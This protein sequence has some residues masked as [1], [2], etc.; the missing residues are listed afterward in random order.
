MYA[1]HLA[2]SAI[3]SGDCDGAIVA[4]ANWINDPSM[5][6]VLDKLGALSPTSRCHTFDAAADGYARGEGFAA[7]YLKKSTVALLDGL[8]IRAMIRGTAVNANG[9]T[10]GITR[11]SARGQEDAIRKAYE[12]AGNLPFEDTA[13]FECHG[14]GTPA[15][16]PLEVAAVGNVFASSRRSGTPEDRLLIGSIKPNLGHTEGASAIASI[17]KVVLSLEAGEIAPTYGVESLN[18]NIDFDGAKVLVVKDGAVP[19]PEGKVRRAS[20]NS[21]GFGGANGHCIIDHVNEVLPGY[22]K[23]G[24]VTSTSPRSNGHGTNGYLNGSLPTNGHVNGNAATHV[25]KHSPFTSG[26]VKKTA[27]ATASTR[28]IVLLPFSAHNT[29]SLQLNIE[30]ISQAVMGSNRY[31]LADVAYTL[32]SKRSR[33]QQRTFRIVDTKQDDIAAGIATEKRVF[34]SPIQTSNVAFIFTGQGAQWH[35]MGAQ[36]FEYGVFRSTISYLDYVL[37]EIRQDSEAPDTDP[38]SGPSA[39]WTIASTLSGDCER[40]HIQ[41]PYVSQVACTAIQLALVDLLASWS[42]RPCAVV[43]HSSGEMAAAYAAG[44]LTAAE[45]IAAAYFRGRAVALNKQKGAMLAVGVGADLVAPYLQGKEEQIRIAAMNSPGSITLSGDIDA[46]DEVAAALSKDGIFHRVLRTSGSAYHSHHMLAVGSEYV[47]MLSRGV[48]CLKKLGLADDS[49]RYPGIPWVS[50]VRPD[51]TM[52]P[53]QELAGPQYWRENL[54]SPVRFTQA[55][56]RLMHLESKSIDILVEIGPHAA[57]KGP[58]EQILKGIG[59]PAQ[60]ISGL[61]R[62]EDGRSSLMQLAGTLFATNAEIDLAAVNSVDAEDDGALNSGPW[63]PNFI[64]GCVAVDLPTYQYTYGP[65]SYY[66]SRMSKEFRLREYL[67]HD[68]LGSD[69][70]AASK[71]HPQWR[72]VLRTKDI[73]W[74]SDHRLLP[75]AVFPAA[76]YIALGVE[77]ASRVYHALPDALGV[78]GYSFREVSIDAALII[79]EDDYGIEIIVSMELVDK[80]TAKAPAWVKFAVT[81]VARDSNDWTQHCTGLVKVEVS[82]P[83]TKVQMST[84]MDPRLPS[85]RAWYDK[86]NDI[87]LGYGKTFQ[88]LSDLQVDPHRKLARA[89]VSLSSTADSMTGGES[90]YPLHPAALDAAFQ[91]AIIAFHG[92][93]LENATAAFVPVR[94][95]QLYL[96]TGVRQDLPATALAHGS[97]SGLR[98]AYA[99]LQ[100]VD[101]SGH[102]FLEVDSMRFAEFRETKTHGMLSEQP[103]SSPFTR[104]VWQPDIRSLSDSQIR[105]I[106]PPPAE[107]TEA[108]AALEVIEMICCLVAFEIYES[109]VLGSE[110]VSPKGDIRHWLA[111]IKRIVEEDY[112]RTQMVEARKLSPTQRRELLGQLYSEAGDRPEAQAAKLLHTNA[113]D[114][115]HERRTGIDILISHK[116]LTPLYEVGTAIAGSHPQVF[117]I[118]GTL[119]HANPN[120]RILEIGAGTGAATRA[121][122][123]ALVGANGIK[124]Y[125]DYTFTDISA[126]FLTSA[127]EMLSDHRDITYSVLDIEQD[128]ISHGYEAVYDIVLACEAIHATESMDRTLAH[129]RSLLKPGGKLVLVETTRMRVLLGLLYG[130]LTGYWQSDDRTEGPFMSLETWQRRLTATG[131]SGVDLHVDDYEAPHN[132]TSVLVTTRVDEQQDAAEGG[133]VTKLPGKGV[134]L[135]HLLDSNDTAPALSIQLATEL[136]RRGVTCKSFRLPRDGSEELCLPTNARVI[137]LLSDQNDLFD[138][139]THRLQAFQY[140]ARSVKSMVW[141]TV[142]SIVKGQDPRGAFMTGLLRVVATENPAGRFLSINI[143]GCI[144]FANGDDNLVRSIVDKEFA[145]QHGAEEDFGEDEQIIDSEFVWQAGCMWVSR[146]VPDTGLGKYAEPIKTPSRQGLDVL[147]IAGHGPVRAAFETA[148][149]FTSVYFR[150]YTEL[151]QPLPVDHIEVKVAAAGLNWRDVTVAMGR[152]NAAGCNLSSEYAGVVTKIGADVTGLSVGD[153]VYGL[154]KGHFGNYE[155]VPAAF[156]QRLQSTDSLVEAAAVPLDFL[157]AVYAFEY[158]TRLRKGCKVLIESTADSLGLAA[159]QVAQAKGA[160]VFAVADTTEKVSTLADIGGIPRDHV[161]LLS[162]Q[163]LLVRATN[164][165][166][167]QGFN[168]ILNTKPGEA[169]SSQL[170]QALAPMGHLIDVGGDGDALGSKVTGLG[171]LEMVQKNAHFSSFDLFDVLDQDPGLGRELMETVHSLRQSGQLK[172][173]YPVSILDVSEFDQALLD[174]SKNRHSGKV[175]ISFQ[176]PDSAVKILR[177]PQAVSFDPGARYIIT[178]GFGGLGRGI[179]RWMADRGAQ[180]FVILSRRGASTPAARVLLE[181]LES[182]GVRVEAI[183]CDVS[184]QDQVVQAISKAATTASSRPIKGVVHAVL[185]LYDLTFDKLNIDQWRSGTVAKTKGSVNMHKATL[186][187]PL[188]FF[189][190]LTSTE[191]IWA[192]ATQAAYIA[193]DNFATYFA[194]YRQRLGLPASTVSYGFVSDL[195]SDYRETSHGTEELYARNLAATMTECQALAMLEPAFL[196]SGSEKEARGW[197]GKQH[198]PLSDA[199]FFTCLSPLDL[200]GLTSTHAPHWHRDGRVA[201]LMRAVSDA[202]RYKAA[203]SSAEQDGGDASDPAALSSTARLRRAFDELIKAGPDERTAAVEL[204]TEGIVRAIAEMLFIDPGSVHPGKTVAEHGV[205]SLI[206]AELRNWFH[207]ALRTDLKNLLDSQTSIGKLAEG[208]VDNALGAGE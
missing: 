53:G 192:P 123:R 9:K 128:P 181:D 167:K 97:I 121:A 43:G 4:A 50:S 189:V 176:N 158:V 109:F 179:I 17:M 143:E 134:G 135:V 208:I 164:T 27:S 90:S 178:G 25:P 187:H 35:A 204:V 150:P 120:A 19:W 185:S 101:P 172:P 177:L 36:L 26:A 127:K 162:D 114:I 103:F 10:G 104:L 102:V 81:S 30:V 66:E 118:M 199:T 124:R 169:V 126:G 206:A 59:K 136:E 159:I 44:H 149:I 152:R 33:L 70:L 122:M 28:Q 75:D 49:Q 197:F 93:Q 110:K 57:L 54:E 55:V 196:R 108:A 29:S 11:P 155:R 73:P 2:V 45:A 174:F 113:A 137:V 72:N 41:S 63:K 12:N 46:V 116:L 161:F 88:P 16:D 132:T 6:I 22:K 20:V 168:V 80:A 190:M 96:K 165:T 191:T 147:P 151:L 106:F 144:D 175:I 99:Q 34:T 61:Q 119:A 146:V 207:Q 188:D 92:G 133:A 42:V 153:R 74:L 117:N 37:Q 100:M 60:Y 173:V 105:R 107:N 166:A 62:N 24:I 79:P 77:A 91:L 98:S 163:E 89:T 184:K 69:V 47:N 38:S 180:D 148:G 198:D 202:R 23:P 131:F 14:T 170:L 84:E 78:T 201:L 200:A 8:P 48:E 87:G 186:E 139:D 157:S 142:G 71:L 32:S 145:L 58:V 94:I 160:E 203:S 31:S 112:Q 65:L 138:A 195:G 1:L 67:R 205:D 154:G 51:K 13:F 86:F 40:D 95:S 15:G 64:H 83:A 76:G 183:A 140:L 125:A 21:F 7:L 68:L 115:L 193:A 82:P 3:R 130:T 171:G 194:R 56:T 111:W 182:R 5:Q 39:S 129:C 52:V 85:I 18:P 156:A 141:L